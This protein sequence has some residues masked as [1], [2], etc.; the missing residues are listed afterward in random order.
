MR[1]KG[2]GEG[3]TE[4]GH[5]IWYSGNEKKSVHR[6]G[7]LVNK[8]IRKLVMEF[9]PVNER[10]TAIRIAGKTIQPNYNPSICLHK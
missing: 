7:F 5:K 9:S 2:I 8:N 3:T 10:I 1:W 6:V 4:D